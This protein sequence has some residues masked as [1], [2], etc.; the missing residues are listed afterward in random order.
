MATRDTLRADITHIRLVRAQIA[1]ALLPSASGPDAKAIDA[2][3]EM[4]GQFRIDIDKQIM[5]ARLQLLKIMGDGNF[6]KYER[7]VRDELRHRFEEGRRMGGE[8]GFMQ[9]RFGMQGDAR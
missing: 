1:E 8:S 5:S 4:K 9:E 7:F 3:I 2:L 6:A